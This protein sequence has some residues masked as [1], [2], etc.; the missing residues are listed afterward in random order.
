MTLDEMLLRAET[1]HVSGLNCAQSVIRQFC[2]SRGL[3]EDQALRLASGFGGGMKV[4]SVCG[5]LSGGI[6]VLGLYLGSA[7][8]ARKAETEA[9]VQE[10]IDRFVV[11]MRSMECSQIIGCDMRDPVQKAIAKQA[12]V[13]DRQ[14][15]KAIA[16]AVELVHD[17]LGRIDGI[18]QP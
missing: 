16:C 17:I 18:G 7:D 13:F 15:S 2:E 5:A 12:G 3:P 14:C 4:G 8:P 10:L 6:M 9:P 11:C 1:D